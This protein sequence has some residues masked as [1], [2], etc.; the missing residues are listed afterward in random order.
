MRGR[1]TKRHDSIGYVPGDT[2]Q[3]DNQLL[4][5]VQLPLVLSEVAF[6]MRLVEYPPLG[7]R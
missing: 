3:R 2:N 6:S 7:V 5:D 1:R 4:V